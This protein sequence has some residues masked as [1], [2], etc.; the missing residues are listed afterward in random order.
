ML[1]TSRHLNSAFDLVHDVPGRLAC[2]LSLR[3]LCVCA[4]RAEYELSKGFML[5][6]AAVILG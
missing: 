5:Y 3:C 6:G 4:A 1:H 2:Q